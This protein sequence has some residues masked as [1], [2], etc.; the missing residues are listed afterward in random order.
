MATPVIMPRQGQS[1][2]SCVIGKW[3]KKK[4]DHVS[5]G[6]VLFSYETDKS[7]FDEE[8]KVE[9][10]LLA[11]FFEE[12][13]EVGCL[14]TVCVIGSEGESADRFSPFAQGSPGP[15]QE[16]GTPARLPDGPA[17][18]VEFTEGVSEKPG[19]ERSDANSSGYGE[20]PFISPR[21]R[22]LAEKTGADLSRAT[23]SGA[24]GRIMESD[25][26]RAV[27]EKHF[28]TRAVQGKA[29][30]AA[31]SGLGGRVTAF[32]EEAYMPNP[33]IPES[34]IAEY[35]EIILTNVR[36]VIARSMHSSLSE[37]AQ[38]T[39]HT[40]F[41]ATDVLNFRKNLKT[42]E[43]YADLAKI[44]VT[45]I[46]VYAASRVLLRHKSLNA[47]FTGEKMIVYNNAHIGVAVDTPRGLLVPT[48]FNANKLSLMEISNGAKALFE[49]CKQGAINPDNLKGGTFTVS[50]LG[51]LG[52]EMFTPILNPPQTGLLG[53]CSGIERTKGGKSY[54]AI[55]LSLTLDHR[56][57]DGADAARFL[58]DLVQY[59]EKFSVLLMIEGGLR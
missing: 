21:A 7:T 24:N 3:H 46:I 37:S 27:S 51:G 25:V 57:L 44:T 15:A 47:H 8:A 59:L 41:D 39:L 23:P 35:E 19:A 54:T 43:E 50:N 11:I 2:E 45:D 5:V 52:V 9:G 6:D 38:L 34:S 53:V 10:V 33:S 4:G 28:A 1:V 20:I 56:A 49:Q 29:L 13:D 12:G 32:D 58:Q 42:L 26:R 40:S 17:Q 14:T 30:Q 36:K 48:V 16:A 18:A 31:G 55:G 22:R